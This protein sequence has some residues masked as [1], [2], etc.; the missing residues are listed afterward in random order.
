MIML[1]STNSA[2]RSDGSLCWTDRVTSLEVAL[3]GG[4]N[5]PSLS[6]PLYVNPPFTNNN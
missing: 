6:L 1:L 3:P 5:F 4:V 2:K